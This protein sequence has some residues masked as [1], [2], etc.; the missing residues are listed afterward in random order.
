MTAELDRAFYQTYMQDERTIS[1]AI[2]P[3]PVADS[4]AEWREELKEGD[5][6]DAVKVDTGYDR[7][8]WG[9]AKITSV[10]SDDYLTIEFQ[11]EGSEFDR[12]L[13]KTSQEI[14]PVDTKNKDKEWRLNLDKDMMIDAYD[15]AS[16]WYNSTILGKRHKQND[17]GTI[18]PELLVGYR[19]YEASGEKFDETGILE[20]G[21]RSM[22]NGFLYDPQDLHLIT[23][24]LENGQY[25]L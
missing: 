1:W 6:I 17:H 7:K 21:L 23:P 2:P 20:D 3:E 14:A 8:I 10:D 5:L 9:T 19:V 22:M 24:M 15:T 11:D 18:T 12:F 16:T 25:H 4:L 13:P